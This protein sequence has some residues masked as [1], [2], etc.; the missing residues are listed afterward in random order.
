LACANTSI[1]EAYKKE[2][3]SKYQE[4]YRPQFHFS[5]D[6]MWMN[7]PNGMVYYEGEYHLFYQY[8]PHSNV[9]GPMHWGHAVSEDLV[10]WE[11]LPIALYPDDSLGTIFS[12]SAV[13]DWN[14]TSGLGTQGDPPLVAIFTLHDAQGEADNRNDFQTQGIA[15]SHDKGRTWTH[16]EGNPV[17]PNPGIRDFRD[18]KVFWHEESEAWVMVLAAR[19]QIMIYRSPNL[20]DWTL[21]STFGEHIGNHGGVWECPDLFELTAEDGTSRWMMIVSI[22][23]GGPNM[24]SA[25]QYFL[26]DFDGKTFEVAPD[27]MKALGRVE[28]YVPPG[29]IFEDFETGYDRWTLEGEAFG[30]QPASG[31]IANQNPVEGFWGTGMVNS[32]LHGDEGTGTLTSVPFTIEKPFINFLIGGGNDRNKT[33]I[34]LLVGE[35]IARSASGQSSEQLE[36]ASWNVSDLMGKEAQLQIVDQATEGWGHINVD[37]IL[38][39]NEAARPAKDKAVWLDYGRDNYA[40]VTWSDIPEEDGRRLFIGWMSNW[41]YATSVPTVKWRSAM[42]IPRELSLQQ[43]ENGYRVFSYPVKELDKLR[44]DELILPDF[45]SDSVLDLSTQFDQDPQQLELELEWKRSDLAKG[46]FV[47]ELSNSVGEVYRLGFDAQQNTFYSDRTKARKEAF[48]DKFDATIS[49]APR[50]SSAPTIKMRV[51]I[52]QSSVEMVAD[53]GATVMTELVFPTEKFD[54]LKLYAKEGMELSQ[55]KVYPLKSIWNKEVVQE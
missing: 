33:C 2:K 48:S 46:R 29:D 4:P 16:Y 21:A 5:P 13:V 42:T 25:T 38:F 23:S 36:W 43:T 50:M 30:D 7:D 40:G 52:D 18:P 39:S 12:G 53:E 44:T 8:H 11:H 10:H 37:H 22:G 47:M 35:E 20:I 9:W 14:N 24:G 26:G 1:D 51:F 6:S 27:F 45:A 15:Y 32:F 31:A 17:I 34:R 41:D 54:S 28:A 19:D 49:T 3:T 55:G